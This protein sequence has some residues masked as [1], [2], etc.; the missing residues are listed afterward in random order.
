M[1]P[2]GREELLE[3]AR[4]LSHEKGMS[5]IF[6]SH[7]LPD[8]E[9][10]CDYVLV[11]GGGR[12]MAAGWL[13]ELKQAHDRLFEVRVKTAQEQFAGSLVS[14][15]CRVEPKEDCIMVELPAGK[16]PAF[17]WQTA[18]AEHK[19]IRHLRPVRSTLE[20]IFLKAIGETN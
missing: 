5:L 1:D 6:S 3:M 17:L 8:V 4:D 10:V 9:A 7:L 13:K 19:Q 16:T 18:S 15:G 20:E 2:A 11:L 14:A 12:L